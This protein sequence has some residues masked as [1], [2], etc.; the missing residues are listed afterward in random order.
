MRVGQLTGSIDPEGWT[1]LNGDTN[2]WGVAG[3]D[4]GANTEHNDRLYFF[5]GDVQK[6][7]RD[8]G[9]VPN[10]DLVAWTDATQVATH[11]GHAAAGF[12][13]VLPHDQT[14]VQGQR[15]WRFCVKCSGLFFNGYPDKGTCS[16]GGGHAAAGFN[17]VLP[18][19][20]TSVQGQRDWRFCVKCNTLFYDGYRDNKG[21]CPKDG[22]AHT[23]VGNNFVLPHDN[24]P[25]QGQRDWRFCVKCNTLFYDGYPAL[26]GACSTG[27]GGGFHL[28]PV[29]NGQ[30]FDPFTV[31]GPI[32]VLLGDETPTGAFSYGG[33]VYVFIWVGRRHLGEAHPPG[34]YLVSKVDPGQPGPYRKEFLLTKLEEAKKGFWQVAPWVV[35]NA[36]HPG[37]PN[38]EGDGVVLFGQ[39]WNDQLWTDAVHLAWMPLRGS[40][41]PRRDEILYY[42]GEPGNLWAPN[43]DQAVALFELRPQYT[44]VSAVWLE[45]PRC[46]IL[47]Y[48]KANDKDAFMASLIARIGTTPWDW[49]Y[50]IELFQSMPRAR[51]WHIYAL[52]WA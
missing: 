10:A 28:H 35:H 38:T 42:T 23:P 4:L 34:S 9:P 18:H 48:S 8:R 13:F 3:T 25:V 26:K 6:R 1:L 40:D 24:T 15:D 50:E 27:E 30:Y 31:E 2:H 7:G 52:A 46:F 47:L 36:D 44:S 51:I 22:I 11:G 49:S 16:M 39:G 43:Q 37:L 12:N 45:G 41:P 19:D 5:F 32:D 33:R 17:F 14:S 29:M 20:Q 21:V